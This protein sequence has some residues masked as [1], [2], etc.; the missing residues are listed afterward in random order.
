[1]FVADIQCQHLRGGPGAG[2]DRGEMASSEAEKPE[3]LWVKYG[4]TQW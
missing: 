1:M 3:R 4:K 2:C